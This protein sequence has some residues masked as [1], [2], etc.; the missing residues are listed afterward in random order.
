M[1][2]PPIAPKKKSTAG[3]RGDDDGA[4]GSRAGTNTLNVPTNRPAAF[5]CFT[6]ADAASLAS[7]AASSA[8]ELVALT[9]KRTVSL[10][11][12]IETWP[13]MSCSGVVSRCSASITEL[14]TAPLLKTV[15]ARRGS[16]DWLSEVPVA[17]TRALAL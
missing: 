9:W 8:L 14:A 5:I 10:N 1:A 13:G 4:A 15:V 6:N 3:L 17:T 16:C 2:K 11:G 12:T 7:F